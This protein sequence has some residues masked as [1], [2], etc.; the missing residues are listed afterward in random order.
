[1]KDS[2]WDIKIV[3]FKLPISRTSYLLF[4]FCLSVLDVCYSAFIQNRQNSHF[5]NVLS[6]F[7]V[8]SNPLTSR[9][10]LIIARCNRRYPICLSLTDLSLKALLGLNQAS[11]SFDPLA[12]AWKIEVE[13][14]DHNFQ[15]IFWYKSSFVY[16]YFLLN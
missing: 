16:S 4:Y 10:V 1:M 5:I 13:I 6:R 12:L 9:P 8:I 15:Y 11:Y 2:R 7:V 14:T 3:L